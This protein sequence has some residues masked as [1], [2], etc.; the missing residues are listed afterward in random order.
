MHLTTTTTTRWEPRSPETSANNPFP[1]PHPIPR[2]YQEQVLRSIRTKVGS[3]PTK[4]NLKGTAQASHSHH[5]THHGNLGI[6]EPKPLKRSNFLSSWVQQRNT[7]ELYLY[8]SRNTTS[9]CPLCFSLSHEKYKGHKEKS[10]LKPPPQRQAKSHSHLS[11]TYYSLHIQI[12]TVLH[13]P[14]TGLTVESIS[15]VLPGSKVT[16]EESAYKGRA[17]TCQSKHL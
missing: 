14:S 17:Q 13:S 7:R 12:T 3:K 10:E 15:S 5:L 16:Q 2:N 1:P 4:Q 11:E 8:L 6:L 9:L